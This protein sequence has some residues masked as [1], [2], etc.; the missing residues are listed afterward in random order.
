MKIFTVRLEDRTHEELR[1]LADANHRS[2]NSELIVLIEQA[3]MRAT[4]TK[5]GER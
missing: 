4:L 1:K 5:D 3:V 2:L